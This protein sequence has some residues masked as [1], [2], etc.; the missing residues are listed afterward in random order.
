MERLALELARFRIRLLGLLLE[1]CDGILRTPK[2]LAS[3]VLVRAS[4]RKCPLGVRALLVA[5]PLELALGV[6]AFL[7]CTRNRSLEARHSATARL[8]FG[9]ETFLECKN[10]GSM[11]AQPFD[12]RTQFVDL[13]EPRLRV[14]IAHLKLLEQR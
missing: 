7:S 5:D 2:L 12:L 4:L 11:I 3:R 8:P 13:G 10:A 14:R 6:F 1:G 9:G